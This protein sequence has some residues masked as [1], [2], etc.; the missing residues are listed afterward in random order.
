MIRDEGIG[1]DENEILRVYERYYQSDRQ[2]RGEGIGLALVKRYCDDERIALRIV[3]KKGEG[4][5]VHLG[6]KRILRSA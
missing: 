3:S 4:T 2:V 6:L 5:S 1:M